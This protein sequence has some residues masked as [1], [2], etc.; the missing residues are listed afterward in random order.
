MGQPVTKY[1]GGMTLVEVLVSLVIVFVIFL[2]LS[3]SG[4]VVLNEEHKKRTAG[5]GR[6]RGGPGGAGCAPHGVRHLATLPADNVLR[7]VRNVNSPS[8]SPGRS[9]TSTGQQ[10][11]DDQRGMDPDRGQP[12]AVVHHPGR[13]DR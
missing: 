9:R 1:N 2:G 11:G 13:D 3:A 10:A 8:P 12:D 7:Q 5:R 6:E 4:L